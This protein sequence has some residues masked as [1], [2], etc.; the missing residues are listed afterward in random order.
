[1]I[2]GQGAIRCH[3][4]ALNEINALTEGDVR[5]FDENFWAHI[6]HVV[7]NKVRALLLSLTRGYLAGSPV[8]GVAAPY[9][10]K[11]AWTSASFAFFA[12]IALGSY[13]GALKMKEKIAG[14]YADILS[15]MFMAAATLRRFEAEG[16]RKEDEIHFKWAMEYIFY[17]IQ[18][19]FD[20][21]LREIRVP[22][23]SWVFRL[24]GVWSRLN[25]IGTYPSDALGSKLARAMQTRG[26]QRDRMSEGIYLPQDPQEAV[27]RYEYAF[28]LISDADPAYRKLYSAIKDRT[29]PKKRVSD[30]ID[31]A[32]EK[33][34]VSSEEAELLR[35]AEDARNDAIQVDDFTQQEYLGKTPALPSGEGLTS[36]VV[37]N[38]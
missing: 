13:G 35:K 17:R 2:F 8:N 15:F 7:K 34:V 1:M 11:L 28:N 21:I 38:P 19:G 5:K 3:P 30:L 23:L 14:R 37:L 4:Y 20:G 25:P 9:F 12:D 18:Q 22:G 33:N 29:L 32:L 6:G 36:E 10:R 24:A 27:G 26:E 16:R 31:E